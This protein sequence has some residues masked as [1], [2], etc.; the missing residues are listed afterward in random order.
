MNTKHP[1]YAFKQHEK[2]NRHIRLE[3]KVNIASKESVLDSMILGAE[4]KT[5]SKIHSNNL[6]LRKCIQT[7]F[8]MI[9]KHIALTDNYG[10]MMQFVA[11]K[12]EEPITLQYLHTCPKNAT[13]LSN[14]SAESLLDAINVYFE[15]KQLKDIKEAPFS[16]LYA[17]EAENSS[18]KECFS[19]FVTYF[20]TQERSSQEWTFSNC[21]SQPKTLIFPR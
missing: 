20:S 5:T 10:D 2:S 1:S 18:H 16:T 7:I 13:Y 8:F 4:K 21:F 19:M 14:T 9:K 12:L 15:T 3:N 6:Y 17:D 11:K